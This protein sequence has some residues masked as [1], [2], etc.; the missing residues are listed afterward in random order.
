[1]AR[2]YPAPRAG[3]RYAEGEMTNEEVLAEGYDAFNRRDSARLR[4]LMVEDFQWNEADEVPGRKVCRSAEE[5]VAYMEGFD[6]LWDDFSFE[7]EKLVPG[8]GGAIV[9]RVRGRGKGR[10]SPDEFELTIHHVWRFSEGRVARMD[11]FLDP[12]DAADAA[13]ITTG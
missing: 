12:G 9:A 6:R 11:A 13:G 10:A 2:E 5:F 7:V 4:E 3:N 8:A 1:M